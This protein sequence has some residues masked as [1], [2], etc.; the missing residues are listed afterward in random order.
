MH[1]THNHRCV[2]D[3]EVSDK[4]VPITHANHTHHPRHADLTHTRIVH[5][6]YGNHTYHTYTHPVCAYHALIT[7][8]HSVQCPVKVLIIHSTG[9]R[10]EYG[11]TQGHFQGAG[12]VGALQELA[13]PGPVRG[14]L[15]GALR[16]PLLVS[17][18]AP[19][20]ALPASNSA[21]DGSPRASGG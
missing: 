5:V 16:G 11:C 4:Y 8:M 18:A 9:G 6:S 10:V 13:P 20:S 21:R 15:A 14:G 1:V 7:H 2:T 19:R 17:T 12:R 3:T